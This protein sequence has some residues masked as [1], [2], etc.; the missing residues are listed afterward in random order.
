MSVH[1]ALRKQTKLDVH[2]KANALVKHTVHI[3]SNGR[4]FDPKYAAFTARI[5]DTTV[6][7]G[8]HLWAAN[9]VLVGERPDRWH[10]RRDLQEGACEE[11]DSLLYLIEVAH[12]LYDLRSGKYFH[13]ARMAT[14]VR[15][16]ARAWRDSDAR[17]YGH[18][19]SGTQ[20]DVGPQLV[21]AF[22][23]SQQRQ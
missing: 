9:N 13:W 3:C 4:V 7:A 11:L 1:K 23:Q 16:L 21:D 19:D 8:Q 5:V 22:G 15:D 2:V 18:L 14:E 12:T 17:R 20:A 6:Q 10:R